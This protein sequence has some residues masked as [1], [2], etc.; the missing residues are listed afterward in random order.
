[1]KK[2]KK[3]LKL[4]KFEKLMIVSTFM[5]VVL[6]PIMS[7]YAKSQLSKVNYEVAETK[8]LISNQSKTNESLEM[9]IN[10]LVSLENLQD[11]ASKMG[12]TYTGSNIKVVE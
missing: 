12:L 5:F 1:M 2:R 10:E 9:K 7:V 8:E 3:K 11:V 4:T 6:S